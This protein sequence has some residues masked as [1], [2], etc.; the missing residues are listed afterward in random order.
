MSYRLLQAIDAHLDWKT[1]FVKILA[2]KTAKSAG[3]SELI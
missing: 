1:R 3:I 2:F